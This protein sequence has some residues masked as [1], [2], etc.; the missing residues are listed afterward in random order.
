LHIQEAVITSPLFNGKL[1]PTEEVTLDDTGPSPK[2]SFRRLRGRSA[3]G[4]IA[5]TRPEDQASGPA[6]Q[7]LALLLE[8]LGDV[9][10]REELRQKLWPADTFVDFDVGLNTAIKRLRD[11]LGDS[12]ESPRY[13]ET[14]HRR[15]YRFIASVEDAI[16][17]DR[18]RTSAKHRR[19]ASRGSLGR[20]ARRRCADSSQS[21]TFSPKPLGVALAAAAGLALL[22]A[23]NLSSL[24][25]HV[26]GTTIPPKIQSLRTA[27]RESQ[28]RFCAGVFRRWH[29]RRAHHRPGQD[30]RAAG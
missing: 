21:R 7:V 14:H 15:G 25:H 9:V 6:F 27:A 23:L 10:T 18:S 12:A 20:Q 3:F 30:R 16:P 13:I 8:Q 5:Q 26:Q 1:S 22:L 19:G 2:G 29:D 11:A 4:R 17:G 24:H 28:R